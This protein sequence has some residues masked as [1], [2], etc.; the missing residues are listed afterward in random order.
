MADT[1]IVPL[2]LA[3]QKELAEV[4]AAHGLT[5]VT[6]VAL[7][8]T[9]DAGL[10]ITSTHHRNDPVHQEIEKVVTNH[11]SDVIRLDFA[12]GEGTVTVFDG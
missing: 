10:R 12:E 3:A 6:G 4:L 1:K 5:N 9:P 8:M 7:T 2:P 11:Y